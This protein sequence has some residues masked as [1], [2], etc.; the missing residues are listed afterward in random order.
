MRRTPNN[1]RLAWAHS[2]VQ[3][4]LKSFPASRA[5]PSPETM[6]GTLVG[7]HDVTAS[8]P[9]RGFQMSQKTLEQV[10]RE[11]LNGILGKS[12]AEKAE[13]GGMLYSERGSFKATPPR[14]Q[15]YGNTVDVGQRQ[16]NKGCPANTLA[17]AYY[18]THP[19]YS[20]GGLPMKYNEFSDEDRAVAT[21]FSLDA[22]L[23]TL[24]GSFFKFDQKTKTTLRLKGR[25]KN[26]TD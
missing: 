18:H 2:G 6:S 22:Y 13:Y 3:R 15:G 25:L 20:A 8:S 16:D 1:H 4:S 26:T 19:G 14:T 23:G 10:A 17:L 7:D 24:D 9:D 21:D 5:G 12:I 11:A